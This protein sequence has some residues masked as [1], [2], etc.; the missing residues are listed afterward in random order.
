MY[1]KKLAALVAASL[2]VA[3]SPAVAAQSL[4][5]SAGLARAG[6]DIS[7]ENQMG[8]GG[9]FWAAVIGIALLAALVLV[10]ID[11]DDNDLP[12]VSP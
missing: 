7:E 12:S 10:V 8:G 3:T 5:P 1:S 6:A 9:G 4:S 2:V 11:D